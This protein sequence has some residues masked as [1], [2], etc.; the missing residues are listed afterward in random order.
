MSALIIV[1]NCSDNLPDNH[2]SSYVAYEKEWITVARSETNAPFCSSIFTVRLRSIR[3]AV[4]ILSVRPSVGLSV[5]P[6]NTCIVTKR[7]HLAKK[8]QL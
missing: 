8:V 6:T 5:C 4:E 7:K 3:I 1:H 2:H